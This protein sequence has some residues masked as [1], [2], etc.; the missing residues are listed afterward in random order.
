MIEEYLRKEY[1]METWQIFV[2]VAVAT[3]V[4]GLA[5]GG[6]SPCFALCGSFI[7]CVCTVR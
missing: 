1:K 7:L 5:V 4:A 3:V 6:V 2:T